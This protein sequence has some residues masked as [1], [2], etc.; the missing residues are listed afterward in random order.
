MF[1]PIFI[2]HTA[3]CEPRIE[4]IVSY[5]ESEKKNQ[6]GG[7]DGVDVNTRNLIEQIFQIEQLGGIE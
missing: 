7:G 4:F 5:C 1:A 6:V 3:P 2:A